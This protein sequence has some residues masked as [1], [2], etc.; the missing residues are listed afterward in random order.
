MLTDEGIL[1]P[2]GKS[3]WRPNAVISILTNEKYSG[4][5]LLQK[6]YT[7]DFLTKK[8]KVNEGE[9][10]QYYVRG[11][12]PAIIDPE[13]FD[14]VQYEMKQRKEAGRWTSS[15]HPFSGKIFCGECGGVYGSK[16]WHPNDEY[17]RAV[18]QCNEKYRASKGC[19]A[20]HLTEAQIQAAFLAAFNDRLD[21]KAEILEAYDEVLRVLTDNTA[22]DTEAAT[23]A[24]ECEVVMELS[25]KAVQENAANVQDQD[26]YR[27]RY[28]GLV[29]RYETA[30]ARL[31]EIETQR[32][33][34]SAKRT[35]ITRFLQSLVK[36]G[37]MVTEFDEELW[38]I[39][40]DSV[41]VYDDGRLAVKFRDGSE[42]EV[43]ADIWKAA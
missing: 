7:V 13:M 39:T 38:Y 30:S 17:R 29:A 32:L 18:W 42:V 3:G 8:Q 12:H 34:R 4:N 14:L 41:T 5:A 35:N 23:L 22:L 33:E 21:S 20:T 26:E 9:I 28:E 16:I 2:G 27:Q 25:R 6:K 36:Y 43:A 31:A 1:T 15:V 40:A 11:S 10:P 19:R 24:E 37:D